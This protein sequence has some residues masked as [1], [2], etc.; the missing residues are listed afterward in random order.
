MMRSGSTWLFNALRLLLE[1]TGEPV[2]AIWFT[3][4]RREADAGEGF[5]LAKL[6]AADDR[7]A[8]AAWRS[9]TCHRD[10]RDVA[11]SLQDMNLASDRESQ[12]KVLQEARDGYDFWARRASLDI[13]Y[14]RIVD[15][16]AGVLG[17]LA[18]D[19]G[20]SVVTDH[21]KQIASA[22]TAMDGSEVESDAP[23]DPV[24]IMHKEHRFDGRP[25]RYADSLDPAT[26]EL[27][28]QTHRDWLAQRGYL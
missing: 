2:Y 1:Q 15:D 26:A 14:R 22:L 12:L 19:L 11:V 4:Y 20:V 17:A 8:R 25:G 28:V 27:I 18:G 10:L 3:D 16:P 7:L 9:Y 24:T 23:Y 5:A 21:L 13:P 6:H